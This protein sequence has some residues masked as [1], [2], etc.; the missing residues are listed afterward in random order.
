MLMVPTTG[1]EKSKVTGRRREGEGPTEG[2]VGP[3]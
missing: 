2:S 1:D 3:T